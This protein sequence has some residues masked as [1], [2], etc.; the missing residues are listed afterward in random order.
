M[1]N[2]GSLDSPIDT[3]TKMVTDDGKQDKELRELSISEEF[4][5]IT[6]LDLWESGSRGRI[7]ASRLH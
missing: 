6:A 2:W 4:Y 1:S 3:A 7:E 5:R